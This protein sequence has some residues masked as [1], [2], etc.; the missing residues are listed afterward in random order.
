MRLPPLGA[1]ELALPPGIVV[2]P[3][4]LHSF[5]KADAG[6]FIRL[7]PG[8]YAEDG[9]PENIQFWKKRIEETDP[10]QGFRVGVIY[11][12][13]GCGK[14]SLVKAAL[15]PHLSGSV[16]AVY[17]EATADD[18]ETR[19]L[20]ALRRHCPRLSAESSLPAALRQREAIGEGRKVLI[21]LDQFEQWLHSTPDD[22]QEGLA[23][24]LRECDG[25][26]L[27]CVVMVRDDFLT[28]VTRF[29]NRLQIPLRGDRNCMLVDLFDRRH[30]KKVLALL[31]Q[32]YGG[33]SKSARSQQGAGYV[34]QPG[35]FG[36]SRGRAC[37]LRAPGL[38]RPDGQG[39]AVDAGDVEGDRGAQGVGV[40]FLEDSFAAESRRD[41]QAALE[42]L[43]AL[44]PE[45]GTSIRGAM[46][47]KQELL[48]KSGYRRRPDQFESLLGILDQKL[49]LVTPTG[50]EALD[51][52][53]GPQAAGEGRYYQLTH[54]Y[55]VPSLRQWL[56]SK[57]KE[58]WR[59]RAEFAWRST[60]SCG[61]TSPRRI[62]CPHGGSC[63]TSCCLPAAKAGPT[64]SG[65]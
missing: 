2:Q 18:T 3:K 8:P 19:L 15:L 14:S 23:E 5:D 9:L 10:E 32:A 24:A 25:R 28:P 39:Q 62:I 53:A 44:L 49:R 6:F 30:A 20:A 58:T 45:P 27:Q 37:D 21:V 61:T 60:P 56:S 43:T 17:V 48:A 46:R 51:A 13:S 59:G 26:R 12:P 41:G 63:S 42:V 40:A 47:T 29:M 7:L 34:S 50:H 35:D 52:E 65:R 33:L 22:E 16:T 38:V 36:V 64:P 1:A 57:Q 55:L 4:G 31:G 54:D 11:G